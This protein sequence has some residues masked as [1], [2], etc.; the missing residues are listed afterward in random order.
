MYVVAT[1]S[2]A[3]PHE[4]GVDLGVVRLSPGSIVQGR[5]RLSFCTSAFPAPL[6]E[7]DLRGIP[8]LWVVKQKQPIERVI[9]TGTKITENCSCLAVC[10]LAVLISVNHGHCVQSTCGTVPFAVM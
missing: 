3:K 10:G 9:A 7:N 4:G 2:C 1:L 8:V 6:R 5:D